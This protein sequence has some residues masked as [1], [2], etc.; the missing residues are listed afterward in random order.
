M[1]TQLG[2]SCSNLS[3]PTKL[4]LFLSTAIIH[5]GQDPGP[6]PALKAYIIEHLGC[7][8]KGLRTPLQVSEGYTKNGA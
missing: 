6:S 5:R 7:I 3:L 2:H 4:I 1:P 8:H